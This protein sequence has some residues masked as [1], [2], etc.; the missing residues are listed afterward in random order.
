MATPWRMRT[1]SPAD[2]ADLAEL[3]ARTFRDTYQ[4]DVDP[5]LL[6]PFIADT[7]HPAAQRAELEDARS[8]ITVV[9]VDGALIGY[10]HLREGDAP[11]EVDGAR[12][13]QVVSLYLDRAWQ[14][15]RIGRS[16]MDL[17]E[18]DAVRGGHDVLWLGVW[19]RNGRAIATYERWGFT[20][21][22]EVPFQLGPERHRDLLMIRPVPFVPSAP[23]SDPAR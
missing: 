10:V 9:E 21:V 6:E 7:F 3:G 11:P 20:Q 23:S 13:L 18:R 12:P 2:A 5:G 15:L 17:A 14:G 4:A 16:L 1:A 22:G 19:E 8:R